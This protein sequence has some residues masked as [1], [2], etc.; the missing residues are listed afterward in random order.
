MFMR[1]YLEFKTHN[2]IPLLQ[3]TYQCFKIN[4]IHVDRKNSHFVRQSRNSH[5]AQ[6]NSG[7]VPILTLRR[8]YILSHR[9]ANKYSIR[10]EVNQL[11]VAAKRDHISRQNDDSLVLQIH[12]YLMN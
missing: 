1:N 9:T 8:T 10:K 11:M 12:Y 4:N 2:S 5:S 6:D 3:L 7:T